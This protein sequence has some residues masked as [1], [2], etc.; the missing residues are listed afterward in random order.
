MLDH[1][2]K[3]FTKHWCGFMNNKCNL[4]GHNLIWALLP[5]IVIIFRQTISSENSPIL[6]YMQINRKTY[7]FIK[8]SSE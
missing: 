8:K 4:A 3:M 1:K 5:A 6:T 2:K 7:F